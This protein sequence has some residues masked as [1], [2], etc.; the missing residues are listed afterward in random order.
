MAN[1]SDKSGITITWPI[2]GI[3]IGLFVTVIGAVVTLGIHIHNSELAVI[4][5][6]TLEIN[7]L[8]QSIID[9]RQ[10][11]GKLENRITLSDSVTSLRFQR[12][13]GER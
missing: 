13:E 12:L 1:G 6:A 5:N 8:S 11:I 10:T 9:L 2:A 4:K 7:N 3:I